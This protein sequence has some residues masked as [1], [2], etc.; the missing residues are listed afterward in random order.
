MWYVW[1]CLP[2]M[3][4]TFLP[5][6]ALLYPPNIVPLIGSVDPGNI[7]EVKVGVSIRAKNCQEGFHC[8]WKGNLESMPLYSILY[9]GGGD[10]S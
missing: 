7:M 4:H 3:L 6:A 5:P 1:N 2:Y 9:L 8:E 10:L